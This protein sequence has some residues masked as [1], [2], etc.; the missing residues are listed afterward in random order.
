MISTIMRPALNSSECSSGSQWVG[1]AVGR[2]RQGNITNKQCRTS[3]SSHSVSSFTSDSRPDAW[4]SG[5]LAPHGKHHSPSWRPARTHGRMHTL[6]PTPPRNPSSR[7]YLPL[8]CNRNGVHGFWL[9]LEYSAVAVPRI[10]CAESR[11]PRPSRM[12][13]C[14]PSGRN[15]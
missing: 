15:T 11:K 13:C 9:P 3:T 1:S 12:R 5:A 10:E 14:Q 8:F 7:T 2:A 4:F 6:P